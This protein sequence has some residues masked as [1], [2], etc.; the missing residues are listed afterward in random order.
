[1]L[2]ASFNVLTSKREVVLFFLS[3][4]FNLVTA[5]VLTFIFLI[6]IKSGGR[7]RIRT[8][9]RG[10]ADLCLATRPLDLEIQVAKIAINSLDAIYLL[11]FLLISAQ[12]IAADTATFNDSASPTLGMVTG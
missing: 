11:K 4:L 7:E 5:M 3:F 8:A 1:M 12:K 6:Y 10:F 9:V 2:V